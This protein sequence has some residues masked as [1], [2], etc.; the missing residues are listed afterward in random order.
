MDERD[1]R[2]RINDVVFLEE[3]IQ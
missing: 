2:A 1:E 3:H